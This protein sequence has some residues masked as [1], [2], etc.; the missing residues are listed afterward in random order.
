M[1]LDGVEEPK[2]R[3]GSRGLRRCARSTSAIEARGS[4]PALLKSDQI[5]A[6]VLPGEMA[7]HRIEQDALGAGRIIDDAAAVFRAVG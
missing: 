7:V 1:A 3:A 2:K 4:S 5:V 6:G